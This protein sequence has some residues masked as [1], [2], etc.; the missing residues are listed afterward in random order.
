LLK[1]KAV[2]ANA[3]ALTLDDGPGSRLTPAILEMLDE[4]NA[5]ATFF[6]LGRNI[7]GREAIARQIFTA[8]HE[9]C[10][11]G[12]DHLNYWKVLPHRAIADIKKGWEAIDKALGTNKGLYP[13]R[14]PGG[15]LNLFCLL[16]LWIRRSPIFYWTLASS[17]T[18]PE[19][20]RDSR[21]AALLTRKTGGAVV[22]IH[23]FDRANS[24][25]DKM[26]INSIRLCLSTAREK[27]IKVMPLS[28]LL[29]L[30]AE[31]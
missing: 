30:S 14:P 15:K 18:W 9:I 21:R 2:K 1:R 22:L 11:H 4:Y 10:S 8:G 5:K 31:M 23:D 24:D 28:G 3:L 27:G 19:E 25:T 29:G 20:K 12:Y 26:V 17:D 13:F 16:Y 6:L 7:A